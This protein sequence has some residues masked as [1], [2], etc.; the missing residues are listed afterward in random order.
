MTG[1]TRRVL[2]VAV[3]LAVTAVML[4]PT[5][6]AHQNNDIVLK[7]LACGLYDNPVTA[8]PPDVEEEAPVVCRARMAFY[9]HASDGDHV[10]LEADCS[11]NTSRGWDP[12][13]PLEGDPGESVDAIE[14]GD[15]MRALRGVAPVRP[16][17]QC[18]HFE[19]GFRFPGD[20][21][22]HQGE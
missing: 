21:G 2:A 14:D 20:D 18:H 12:R 19:F 11:W 3:G 5:A 4:A 1:S 9:Y 8:G 7:E 10:V 22:S 13:R 15:Y 16:T 6:L 17:P